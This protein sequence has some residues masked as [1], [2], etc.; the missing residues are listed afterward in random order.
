MQ[1]IDPTQFPDW[2]SFL[3]RNNNQSFFHTSAWA[4]V[5]KET[6]RYKP[7]YFAQI[8]RDE[9]KMLIPFMEI[10]SILTGKRGVSLPFSDLCKPFSGG[11]DILQETTSH[12]K[13]FGDRAGWRY[14]EWRDEDYFSD[15]V[16]PYKIHYTHDI[17]LSRPETELFSSLRDSNRRSIRKAIKEGVSIK[18][19]NALDAVK[20]FYRLNCITRKRHGL[21]PQPYSFF[22]NIFKHII[23]KGDGFVI[24]AFHSGHILAASVFFHFGSVAVYKY[25]ASDMK[26]QYLRPNNLI[27]WEA[28]KW[29]KSRGTVSLNLGR[30]EL[31]NP[32]L[33]KYKRLW[34]A[35]EGFVKYYRYDF[36]KHIFIQSRPNTIRYVN[37]LFS[38]IPTGVL[39]FIGSISYKHMG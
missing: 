25:G 23:Q 4:S 9:L 28:M 2:D 6:Y 11:K 30:T 19:S 5:L 37:K 14:A 13:D 39:R 8:E 29:F 31:D 17:N 38:R 15:A 32:G 7:L 36:N 16:R 35:G 21:P 22:S 24:S 1:I 33:L 3:L 34:G 27:M 20:S 18:I 12:V 26:H 10:N